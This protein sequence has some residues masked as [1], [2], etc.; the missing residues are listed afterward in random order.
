M[1]GGIPLFSHWFWMLNCAISS[2]GFVVALPHWHFIV[3]ALVLLAQVWRFAPADSITICA[4]CYAL[5]R[6][7]TVSPCRLRQAEQPTGSRWRPQEGSD[8][9]GERRAEKDATGGYSGWL[10]RRSLQ[11][12]QLTSDD[13]SR[14]VVGGVRLVAAVCDPELGRQSAMPGG[15]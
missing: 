4:S 3:L 12:L 13:R 15:R 9:G 7:S 8:G 2:L 5:G 6:R 10:R 1:S 14:S 11:V